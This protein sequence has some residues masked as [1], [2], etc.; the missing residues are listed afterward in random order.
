LVNL[1]NNEEEIYSIMFTSLKH[2]VRRKILRMLADKPMTFMEMVDHLGV[3]SSHLTYHLE[4][5][6]ELVSKTEN[7][8][9][10]LSSFGQATVSAMKGVEEVPVL[11]PKRRLK[12]PFKWKATLALLLIMVIL[13]ASMSTLQFLALDEMD[14]LRA[15][16]Q[17][18]LSWGISTNKVVN[19]L[20]NIA[21]I[22]TSKYVVKLL[23][24]TV[25]YRQDFNV[26]E[27][28]IKYSLT[29]GQSSSVA[30]FRF[31]SNH[32]SR[33]QLILTE[34]SE[35]HTTTQAM[36]VLEIAKGALE[37]Y[38]VY[39]G[40]TYLDDMTTLLSQVSKVEDTAITQGNLKLKITSAGDTTDFLWMYTTQGI[41]F[42]AKSLSMTFS[43]KVL[44]TMIDGYFLFTVG[45]TNLATNQ[46]RAVQIAKDHAKT[47]TWTINGQ[48]IMGF[49]AVD[50]PVSVDLLPHPRANSVALIPYWYVTLRLDQ[51]YVGGINQIAIGVYADNG[52][53]GDVQ[54]LSR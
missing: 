43:G 18:L 45:N 16:N 37:G 32:F 42:S 48:Q 27:E 19:L 13:L 39:S 38:R 36:N 6:G 9:Y 30:D 53:I 41:D 3:S 25:Q 34:E 54:M 10:K 40:D 52:E 35:I 14:S 7:G 12:L 51:T 28:L 47:L 21:H 8:R 20:Q 5:L 31:R 24:N 2:P 15:E 17:Q 46:D 50:S 11:E 33:Y 4:S 49:T 26:P 44:T 22:D 1:A 29:S 23:D